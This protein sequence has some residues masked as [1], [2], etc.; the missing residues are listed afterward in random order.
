[1]KNASIL[2]GLGVAFAA[3]AASP[4]AAEISLS[5]PDDQAAPV[6]SAAAPSQAASAAEASASAASSAPAAP[7]AS[8]AAATSSDPFA[9]AVPLSDA[10]LSQ[11]RG[12][13]SIVVGNQT[14]RA[15]TSG[16]IVNGDI[17]AG[18]VNISDG[19]L[20]NFNG[21]GNFAINTG[22]QVSLQSGMNLIINISQ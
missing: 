14:L 5:A 3:L 22:T 13:E 10:D 19:A 11:H 9:Q 20:A 7:A 15:V 21:V 2:A 12:G 16:N 1:M 4:A 18:A 6:V 8:P 17:T